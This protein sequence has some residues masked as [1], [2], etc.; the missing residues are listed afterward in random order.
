MSDIQ[1]SNVTKLMKGTFLTVE[2]AACSISALMKSIN[3]SDKERQICKN[4][5]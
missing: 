1:P 3:L 5:Q 2:E 4:T